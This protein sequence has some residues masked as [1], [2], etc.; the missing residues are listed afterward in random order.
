MSIA[1]TGYCSIKKNTV[2]KD[3]MVFYKGAPSS[4]AHF[5]DTLYRHLE[6]NYPKFHKM[7][8]LSKLGFLTSDILLNNN[9]LSDVF[10]PEK[11]GV[12]LSNKS[13]SMDTDL[14]YF[15]MVQSGVASP[16][17]F[18][19]SL[20]NIVI[21]EICIRNG[22]KGENTFFITDS[23]DIPTQVN[24]INQLFENKIIDA[25]ICGWMELIG[26]NYEAFL[27]LVTK[28]KLKQSAR[29]HS[30]ESIN[31]IYHTV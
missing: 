26:E 8:N 6:I 31:K 1:I 20:P 22:I 11:T 17:V 3:G 2:V 25:C 15:S 21:G 9:K 28:N 13:S 14:K 18:V 16:A 5:A 10:G 30:V 12:I 27:Y 23:Y 4:F 24:Y 19:Y 7:D 29:P